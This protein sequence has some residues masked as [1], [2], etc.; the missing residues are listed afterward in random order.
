MKRPGRYQND[1]F[2][3]LLIFAA[4]SPQWE[5]ASDSFGLQII[6]KEKII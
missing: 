3:A 1:I 6:Y 5:W 2:Q 4:E